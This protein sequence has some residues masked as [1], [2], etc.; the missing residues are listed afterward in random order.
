MVDIADGGSVPLLPDTPLPQPPCSYS[1]LPSFALS[2]LPELPYLLWWAQRHL[3]TSRE[4]CRLLQQF[5]QIGEYSVGSQFATEEMS[6]A[7]ANCAPWCRSILH[8]VVLFAFQNL[9][10]GKLQSWTHL[11]GNEPFKVKDTSYVKNCYRE[12]QRPP[13]KRANVPSKFQCRYTSFWSGD[14][15]LSLSSCV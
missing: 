14:L 1:S 10:I 11:S 5:S 15:W 12:D 7:V 6:S 13:Q 3:A 8:R 9:A 4:C 2:L